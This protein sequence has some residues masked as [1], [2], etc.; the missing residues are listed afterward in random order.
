MENVSHI[1]FP[2]FCEIQI[3]CERQARSVYPPRCADACFLQTLSSGKWEGRP[4]V[5]QEAPCLGSAHIGHDQMHQ[6]SICLGGGAPG[7]FKHPCSAGKQ[8]EPLARSQIPGSGILAAGRVI[9]GSALKPCVG[10]REAGGRSPSSPSAASIPSSLRPR[11]WGCQGPA[12]AG[13]WC[14]FC[15]WAGGQSFCSEAHKPTWRFCS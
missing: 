7:T 9:L 15:R 4:G 13:P 11:S 2:C 10:H 14:C 8:C 3:R 1:H 5:S 12:W 6:V